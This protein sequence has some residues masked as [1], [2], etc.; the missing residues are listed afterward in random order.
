MSLTK[1]KKKYYELHDC[2][3]ERLPNRTWQVR[4]PHGLFKNVRVE[5]NYGNKSM[6]VEI[7]LVCSALT[8]DNKCSL[9]ETDKKP[10][11][12]KGLDENNAYKYCLTEGCIYQNGS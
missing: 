10:Y 11:C 5:T 4:I 3:V 1:D 6:L 7:P 12:C 2:N 9:H 8:P